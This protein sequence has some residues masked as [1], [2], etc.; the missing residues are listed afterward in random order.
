MCM[1]LSRLPPWA[2]QMSCTTMMAMATVSSQQ[3]GARVHTLST[4]WSSRKKVRKFSHKNNMR[5]LGIDYGTKRVGL[6]LSDEG[7]NMAFP[8]AVVKNDAKLNDTIVSF[9][10][11]KQVGAIVIGHSLAMKRKCCAHRCRGAH[12]RPYAGNR[13]PDSSR[14]RMVHNGCRDPLSGKDR[15][16]RCVS[17]RTYT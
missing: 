13:T 8:L 14:T 2:R 5:Y 10:K 17:R 3:T 6:A 11:E 4:P 7:G 15:T 16:Q 1:L 12:A 9:V